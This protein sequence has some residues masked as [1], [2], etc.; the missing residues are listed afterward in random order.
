VGEALAV[1]GADWL[2]RRTARILTVAEDEVGG[3][4]APRRMN[5]IRQVP[6]RSMVAT[7]A[8]A[9]AAL[10]TLGSA[11]PADADGDEWDQDYECSSFKLGGICLDLTLGGR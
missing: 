2:L 4:A 1:G 5:V 10:M 6:R 8:M 7:A 9:I 3:H 11:G